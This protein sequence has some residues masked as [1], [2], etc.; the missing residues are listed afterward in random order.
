MEWKL[1]NVRAYTAANNFY[2]SLF[3]LICT[4]FYILHT[5]IHWIYTLD[6]FWIVFKGVYFNLR[7]VFKDFIYVQVIIR[8]PCIYGNF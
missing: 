2:H 4:V 6:L 3:Y 1:L 7:V 8:D 5:F